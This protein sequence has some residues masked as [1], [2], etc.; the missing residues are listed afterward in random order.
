MLR[1]FVSKILFIIQSSGL[2]AVCTDHTVTLLGWTSALTRLIYRAQGLSKRELLKEFV[3]P[4]MAANRAIQRLL[5]EFIDLVTECEA[6][7][8]ASQ[9]GGSIL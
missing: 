4:A 1:C 9:S 5:N 8:K 7:E 3:L 6:A 2:N